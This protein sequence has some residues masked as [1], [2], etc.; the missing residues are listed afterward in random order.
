MLRW[1]LTLYAP[2]RTRL[3]IELV[4]AAVGAWREPVTRPSRSE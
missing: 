4:V 2:A 1:P 3:L